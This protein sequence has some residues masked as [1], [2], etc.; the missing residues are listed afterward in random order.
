MTTTF[1]RRQGAS[2]GTSVLVM[3]LRSIRKT[4]R[5]PQIIFSSSVQSVAFLL[6]FRY[7]FG[8]A[9]ATGTLS[10]VDFMVPG[11]LTVGVLFS[12]MG[13]ATG[14]AEDM[15][16]GVFDRLRSLPMPRVAVLAGRVVADTL[17]IAEVLAITSVIAFAI[18][19][20]VHSNWLSGMLAF[21]LCVLFGFAFDWV[22]VTL[23]LLAGNVQAAQGLGF[24]VL[25][26]I[27]VS[28]AFVPVETMP[29]WLQVFAHY[30]PITMMVNAIRTLTQGTA[31]EA[32]L[33]HP[34]SHYVFQS[35]LWTVGIVAIFA[36]LAVARFHRR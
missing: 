27:F 5:T 7:I 30:Q 6:I 11:L 10:Y 14:I 36:S 8:G 2:L 32:I 17:L 3:A 25:P 26:L 23:G 35:L 29:G 33:G 4:F 34:A 20:R 9:I 22:F 1:T 16:Q 12:G 18:G 28:S 13:S 24:L 15:Q 19:F 21:G 31:A